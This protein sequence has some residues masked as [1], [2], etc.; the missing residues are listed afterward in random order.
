MP[1]PDLNT[2]CAEHEDHIEELVQRF[3][4]Y[5]AI[6]GGLTQHHIVNWLSQFSAQHWP[7][8]LELAAAI[9]YYSSNSLN[10]VLRALK[11]T[12]N[13]HIVAEQVPQDSVCY[14]PGG[15]TAE[16]GQGIAQ[17]Y[18]NVNRLRRRRNQFVD[19]LELQ[20]RLFKLEN[21]M[22]VFL[23]DFI[24]TG[25]QMSNYWR[26]VIS[27]YVPEY[28]PL[29]LA[30]AAAFPD[31]VRRIENETPLTILVAHPLSSRHQ[32]LGGH[33]TRFTTSQKSTLRRYCNNW[34]NHPLGFGNI[35]ALVVPAD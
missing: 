27:Q 17:L 29:F 35:G 21:P 34:G 14:V 23:D 24:G 32:L 33:N 13:E 12:I 8:A 20:E 16:S 2:F 9:Q 6:S 5:Q 26:D 22:V 7:L 3:S 18:R 11:G 4:D 19:L 10:G 25:Q 15:R 30:V 28:L 31:G 1:K